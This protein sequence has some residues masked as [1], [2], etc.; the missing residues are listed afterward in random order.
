MLFLEAND[1]NVL[2]QLSYCD[3]SEG[4]VNAVKPSPLL[5]IITKESTDKCSSVELK[6]FNVIL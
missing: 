3:D 1:L 2:M 4:I 5:I 6:P